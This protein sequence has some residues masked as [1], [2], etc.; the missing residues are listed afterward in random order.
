MELSGTR[1]LVSGGAAGIGA[2]I[3]ARLAAEGSKVLVADLDAGAGR[4]TAARVGGLF[5]QLDVATEAGVMAMAEA[6][7]RQLGGLDVLVNNAGGVE[8]PG[9]PAAARP[10][11]SRTL[12]L[13]L[14]AVMLATQ[15][16]LELMPAHGGAVVN[17][18]SVAGLGTAVHDAPEYAVAKA[19]V[20][21]LTACLAPL[22]ERRGVR[23]NCICPSL[24]DTPASRRSR[25]ALGPDELAALPPAMRPDDIADA[26]AWLARDDRL[27]GRVLVCSAGEPP[28]LLPVLDWRD[29]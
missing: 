12:D 21:R 7:R 5:A 22:R 6:A 16:A 1:A 14:R 28:R 25:A 29:L 11:W 2:A 8:G 15:L 26:A 27:A 4:D 18:A 20:V 17:I 13:N 19:G 9:Y 23:V 3:A 10:D 24:V